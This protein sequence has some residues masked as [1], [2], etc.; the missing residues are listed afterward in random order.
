MEGD[1]CPMDTADFDGQ[2]LGVFPWHA[3]HDRIFNQRLEEQLNRILLFNLSVKIP[4]HPKSVLIPG[5][6]DGNIRF[7]IPDF[8][9]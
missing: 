9:S 3:M 4:D 5:M 2:Q 1:G 7:C 8:F 6:L